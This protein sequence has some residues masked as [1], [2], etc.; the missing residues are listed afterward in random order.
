MGLQHQ[1]LPQWDAEAWLMLGFGGCQRGEGSI[2][3]SSPGGVRQL[4]VTP[5]ARGTLGGEGPKTP[6]QAST[7]G[8]L[9]PACSRDLKRD[10][11]KKLE[12]LEKRTQRAI[13]ELIRKCRAR[14]GGTPALWVVAQAQGPSP[15]LSVPIQVRG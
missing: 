9:T 10:V 7:S 8:L 13:A 3:A 15:L 12:K 5:N 1:S 4:N 2:L 14:Q 11:A 6:D